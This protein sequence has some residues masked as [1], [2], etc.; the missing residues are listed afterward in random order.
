[1]LCKEFIEKCGGKIWV[2]SIVRKGS[3]FCF[4]LPNDM[5]LT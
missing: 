2:E 1:M 3:R 5:A 4:T